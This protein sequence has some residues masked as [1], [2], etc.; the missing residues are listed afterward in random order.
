MQAALEANYAQQ[1]G[2]TGPQ[3]QS[4]KRSKSSGAPKAE[5]EPIAPV[6]NRNMSEAERALQRD[7]RLA[8]TEARVKQQERAGLS[9]QGYVDMKFKEKQKKELEM[10]RRENAFNQKGDDNLAWRMN[11]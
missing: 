6:F 1:R 5:P 2:R 3:N 10:A 4:G 9:K 7:E 11:G 8:A